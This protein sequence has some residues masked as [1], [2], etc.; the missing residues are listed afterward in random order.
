MTYR[1]LSWPV[2]DE[3]HPRAGMLEVYG[4]P[5]HL[6]ATVNGMK[7]Y[8]GSDGVWYFETARPL[9]PCVP[10]IKTVRVHPPHTDPQRCADFRVLRLIPGRVVF[11]RY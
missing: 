8:R 5:P 7:G 2:P 9:I 4:V 10:F 11:L 3:K 6:L 1:Q